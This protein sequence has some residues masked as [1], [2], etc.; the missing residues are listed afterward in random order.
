MPWMIQLH[1]LALK[2][3]ILLRLWS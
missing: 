1:R 3:N 2:L